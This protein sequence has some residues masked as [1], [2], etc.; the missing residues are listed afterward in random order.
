MLAVQSHCFGR[1]KTTGA[2]YGHDGNCGGALPRRVGALPLEPAN[3]LTI[4]S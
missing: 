4:V 1:A 2:G 3:G